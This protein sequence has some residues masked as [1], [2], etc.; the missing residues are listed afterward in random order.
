MRTRGSWTITIV[1]GAFLTMALAAPMAA[2]YAEAEASVDMSG[3]GGW[4]CTAR[5]EYYAYADVPVFDIGATVLAEGSGTAAPTLAD[6]GMAPA[7]TS[8]SV[9]WDQTIS[10][11]AGE[12][13]VAFAHARSQG[14][15]SGTQDATMDDD[16]QCEEGVADELC[17]LNLAFCDPL[18]PKP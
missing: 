1:T 14:I 4:T 7:K 5:I 11:P 12:F 9:D 18:R 6:S 3:L 16:A 17:E 13:A 10:V 15:I 2:S 8:A